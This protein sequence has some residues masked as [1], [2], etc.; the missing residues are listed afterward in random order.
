[1]ASSSEEN[2]SGN[3]G[4]ELNDGIDSELGEVIDKFMFG[5]ISDE[6]LEIAM[7]KYQ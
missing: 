4:E 7:K 5:L 3:F 2:N 1:M 6:E